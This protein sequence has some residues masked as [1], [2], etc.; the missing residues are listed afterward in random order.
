MT[1]LFAGSSY[2]VYQNI[3]PD[4]QKHN[5]YTYIKMLMLRFTLLCYPN[6]KTRLDQIKNTCDKGNLNL[7]VRPRTFVQVF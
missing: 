1:G 2:N 4:S 6:S 7:L 5:A 3:Y